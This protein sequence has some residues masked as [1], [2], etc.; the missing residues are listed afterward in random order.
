M[1]ISSFLSVLFLLPLSHATAA[2]ILTETYNMGVS[3]LVPDADLNGI[4]QVIDVSTSNLASIDSV[5]VHLE[6]TGGWNGDLYAYLSHEGQLSV[7]VNRPGRTSLLTDG[8]STN[9]MNLTLRDDAATDVHSTPGGVLGGTF[10]PDQR[11][12]HPSNAMD[13]DTRTASLSLFT[14]TA[15]TGAWRLFIA[16]VAGG[17]E[18]TLTHWSITLTG[19]AAVPEPGCSVLAGLGLLLLLRRSTW[20]GHSAT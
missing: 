18:A 3:T 2:T 5:V 6:T 13:T 8:A 10:Q 14:T 16:D 15:P 9:G 4:V 20:R 7:L 1:K 17:E 19:P 12:V 11:A